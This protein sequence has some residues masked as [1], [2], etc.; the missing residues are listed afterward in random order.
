MTSPFEVADSPL[1][2]QVLPSSAETRTRRVSGIHQTICAFPDTHAA[3]GAF[4]SLAFGI[5][6]S[7]VEHVLATQCLAL[8]KSRNMRVSIDGMLPTGVTPKDVVLHFIG[9]IGA[10]GAT[11][12]VVEFAGSAVRAMSMEAR[13]SVCNMS[14][15]AGARAGLVAPDETTFAYLRG[16]PLAPRGEEWD[17]AV[18]YWRT[19]Q[20]DEGAQFDAE[21]TIHAED[22][23]PTV[24]WGTSPQDVV[25]ILGSTP[26]PAQCADIDKRQ[27]IERALKYMGLAPNTPMRDVTIDKVFIGSCT[28]GR[29]E[30]LREAAKVVRAAGADARVPRGVHAMVV[31]GYG[32]VKVRAEAEGLDTIFTRAGFDWREPGCSLCCG[33][34]DTLNPEE[35]CAST[36]NRNFEGRQGP[37]SRTHLLSPAMAAAAALTGRL[38]DVRGILS[39]ETEVEPGPAMEVAPDVEMDDA[40]ASDLPRLRLQAV[41]QPKER[42]REAKDIAGSPPA[43]AAFMRVKGIAAP[44]HLPNVDTDVIFP[45]QFCKTLKRTGLANHLFFSL[46]NDV[47]SGTKTSFVL[48]R[49]PYTEAKILVC[50]MPNFGCGSSREHATWAM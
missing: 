33:L 4:G 12:C 11:G 49:P 46:R 48:N 38:T 32:L 39:D 8:T 27:H 31:P 20:S 14:V 19:L 18:Q 15:E 50:D 26:D 13:M 43:N 29:I 28:N 36:S 41:V 37:R 44:L 9:V 45:A 6:T 42:S 17:R 10:A 47:R 5:G 40:T 34:A 25:S 22:I 7:A 3:H 1:S 16:R 23:G 24:T 30:D 2:F 21:V 35:R